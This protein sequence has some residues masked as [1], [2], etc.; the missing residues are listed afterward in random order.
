[1]ADGIGTIV[2]QNAAAAP[3][4]ACGTPTE[5]CPCSEEGA[6]VSCSGPKIR[7]GN[8]TTCTPGTRVCYGGAWSACVSKTLYQNVDSV[9]QDYASPCTGN[10]HVQWGALKIIGYAPGDSRVDV[11]V[12][13]ADTAASL[14]SAQSQQVGAFDAQAPTWPTID[15][16][17]ALAARGEASGLQLRVTVALVRGTQGQSPSATWQQ[18]WQCV[19]NSQ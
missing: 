1:M 4:V 8:Y 13:T 14:D 10:T 17:A 7:T 3:G 11:S 5:G 18:A 2:E 12:Q 19:P 15:V 6:T 9:S 16:G